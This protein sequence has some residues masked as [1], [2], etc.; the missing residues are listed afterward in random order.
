M[1]N[2]KA[3]YEEVEATIHYEQTHEDCC[4]PE[5]DTFQLA[6]PQRAD[7]TMHFSASIHSITFRTILLRIERLRRCNEI[8]QQ[9][10]VTLKK[11]AV[12]N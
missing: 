1:R 4:L 10:R 5:N 12:R 11:A 8:L 6:I 9:K 7:T 3:T 2:A